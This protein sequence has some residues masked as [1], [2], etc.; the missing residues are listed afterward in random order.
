MGCPFVAF[1]VVSGNAMMGTQS[2]F[3][4]LSRTMNSL[5]GVHSRSPGV[6][7]VVKACQQFYQMASMR[8]HAHTQISH[9]QN[10]TAHTQVAMAQV[11]PPTVMDKLPSADMGDMDFSISGDEWNDMLAGWEL[12]AGAEDARQM[13]NYFEQYQPLLPP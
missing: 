8:Y 12:G 11:A 9:Q 5:H 3:E 13:A 2:D 10:A 7:R 6:T 1:I 4:L